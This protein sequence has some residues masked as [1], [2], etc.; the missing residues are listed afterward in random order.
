MQTVNELLDA[1]KARHGIGSDYKLARF[2]GLTEGAVR[3]YR[4]MRSMPD[5]LACVKIAGALD[6][7]GDVLAAQVQAQRARDEETR[8]FWQRIAAR[9]QAGAVH[10]ALLAVLVGVGFFGS[11]PSAHATAAQPDTAAR[12]YIM[13][14]FLR[15]IFGTG[16]A[17]RASTA[18]RFCHV[19]SPFA[20]APAFAL[21]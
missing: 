7:D 2:L 11:S 14:S 16:K 17:R 1:V 10:S 5:E 8:A 13:L 21:A 15:A 6:L 9:L 12:L 19:Q 18:A 20:A 3:N 4:H